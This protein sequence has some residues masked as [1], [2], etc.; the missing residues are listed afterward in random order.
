MLAGSI[1]GAGTGAGGSSAESIGG[2]GTNGD[3]PNAGVTVV[4][5]DGGE[6]PAG[7]VAMTVTV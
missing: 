2:G 1:S 3:A 4:E 6:S 5:A 7:L